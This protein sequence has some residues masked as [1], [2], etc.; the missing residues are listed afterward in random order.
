MSVQSIV[1]TLGV[2][3]TDFV[4]LDSSRSG[5]SGH[6]VRNLS[7]FKP[8][9]ERTGGFNS[10]PNNFATGANSFGTSAHRQPDQGILDHERKR[11][12]ELECFKLREELEEKGLVSLAT[13]RFHSTLSRLRAWA[14]LARDIPRPIRQCPCLHTNE[15]IVAIR[16]AKIK[17]SPGCHLKK[18]WG[19]GCSELEPAFSF[20]LPTFWEVSVGREV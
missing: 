10:K 14:S 8:R 12:V 6:I 20:N 5:T 4:D 1:S 9:Q 2:T 11:K 16:L 19:P 15:E 7:H 13:S 17:P 3:G 18:R